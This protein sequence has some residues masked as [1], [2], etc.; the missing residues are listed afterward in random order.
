[1]NIDEIPGALIQ[2][3]VVAVYPGGNR[4]TAGLFLKRTVAER[5]VRLL[6]LMSPGIR[7]E[8]EPPFSETLK[9]EEQRA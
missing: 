5:S 1:V 4:A 7:H 6:D 3:R 8:I 2:C 9:P